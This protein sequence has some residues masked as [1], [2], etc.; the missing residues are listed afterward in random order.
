MKLA[1]TIQLDISDNNVYSISASPGEWAITG[2]F[3]FVD[4]N[5]EKWGKKEQIA[6]RDGWLGVG[7]YGRST[8]VQISTISNEEKRIL[9]ENLSVLILKK[10]RAPGML[11]ALD[12]A[13]KEIED[14]EKLCNHPNG[15]LLSIRRDINNKEI[16]EK[17]SIISP[18]MND[19]HATIWS[20][21]EN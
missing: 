20:I 6:F 15:T 4:S 13:Q 19:Q 7:S 3:F 9:K 21:E 10:F 12:A 16:K 2:T 1:K 5:P 18:E 17:V 8:L 11:A 14:M